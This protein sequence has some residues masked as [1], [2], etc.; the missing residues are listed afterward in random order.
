MCT[1]KFILQ[2]NFF[3]VY[4]ILLSNPFGQSSV[5]NGVATNHPHDPL[6][7]S[8]TLSE[9]KEGIETLPFLGV[10]LLLT[11]VETVQ[12]AL[13]DGEV[14][15]E[16]KPLTNSGESLVQFLPRLDCSANLT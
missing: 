16:I 12:L 8:F 14:R 3:K 9:I 6:P 1:L 13:A 4:V 10:F 15:A 5:I 2:H 7:A 11:V